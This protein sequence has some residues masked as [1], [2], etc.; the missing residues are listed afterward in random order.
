MGAKRER[1]RS[2]PFKLLR[3]EG[4]SMSPTLLDRQLVFAIRPRVMKPD[5]P[6]M[7]GKIV[8]FHHPQRWQSIYVKRIV[9]LPNEYISIEEKVVEIDGD[10]LLEPYLYEATALAPRGASKWF[11]GCDELFLLGDNRSDSEDSR[12]F[13]PVRLGHIIGEVRFRFWP[14]GFLQDV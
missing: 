3:I 2:A 6:A 8:A 14:P 1:S 10:L 5:I 7:R 11:T 9:G 13:G 12:T 4:N